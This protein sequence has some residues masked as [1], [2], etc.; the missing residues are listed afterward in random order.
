MH[1]AVFSTFAASRKEPLVSAVERVYAAFVDAGFGAPVIRFSLADAPQVKEAAAI[2]ALAGYKRVSSVARVLKRFPDFDRFARH[3]K[4]RPDGLAEVQALSNVTETGSVE[5]VDFETIRAIAAGVPRS[6]PFHAA[7]LHFTAPG[8]SEG[9]DLPDT[10]DL[11]TFRM[12]LR[13][14][15]EIGGASPTTSGVAVRDSWWVNA[16]P[17]SMA[18]LR[19][20][21]ADP[22]AKKLPP[23]PPNV[24]AVFAACGKV[25]K[26]VQVPMQFGT[27]QTSTPPAG[28]ADLKSTEAGQAILAVLRAQRARLLELAEHLPH[29]LE[30]KADDGPRLSSTSPSGPKK[31]ELDRVFGPLGYSCRGGHGTFALR[32]R[33][34]GNLTVGLSLDTGTWSN[35][36]LAHFTV[37]GMMGGRGWKITMSLPPSR[38]APS[39]SVNGVTV[40][41]QFPIGGPDRWRRIV[42]N[43]GALVAVLDAEFVPEIEAIAGP[44]PAWYQIAADASG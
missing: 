39:G 31:P 2:E 15:A 34:A 5:P 22:G 26:T 19:V 32:R 40:F 12:L 37:S 9:P 8:F 44:T 23:P 27:T 6:F 16:R 14:G 29:D 30:P 38:R 28:P 18:A 1:V 24:A 42:E 41:G 36:V 43:L 10:P 11:V 20:V 21:V 35:R 3:R 4:P 17:R 7:W 33:T 25:R 13:A